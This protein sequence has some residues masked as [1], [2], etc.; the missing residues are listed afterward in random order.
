M[1]LI[2]ELL[3]II[4]EVSSDINLCSKLINSS[5]F[6]KYYFMKK[7]QRETV[8]C[9]MTI[10]RLRFVPLILKLKINKI[11]K[12]NLDKIFD[13]VNNIKIDI[14]DFT[15]T[16][17][18]DNDKLFFIEQSHRDFN[19]ICYKD[20]SYVE[21]YLS[22]YE[23][24]MF[25]KTIKLFNNYVNKIFKIY[26]YGKYTINEVKPTILFIKIKNVNNYFLLHP[27]NLHYLRIEKISR[28]KYKA[29]KKSITDDQMINKNLIFNQICMFYHYEIIVENIDFT[30]YF[31]ISISD[32][33]RTQRIKLDSIQLLD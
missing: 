2:P 6:M 13:K 25:S 28:A 11:I 33:I 12:S 30:L 23:I 4:F 9:I 1:K 3:L 22:N 19:L 8:D 17:I 32:S 10:M 29:F 16:L 14:D 7:Y 27:V 21:F 31:Q 26:E 20:D 5:S 15:S 24:S 18:I